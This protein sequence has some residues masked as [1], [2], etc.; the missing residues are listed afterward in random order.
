MR[1]FEFDEDREKERYVEIMPV[2]FRVQHLILMIT[3]GV[4]F[5]SGFTVLFHRTR[6]SE[7]LVAME[8]GVEVRGLLH[9]SA[10]V[11]LLFLVLYHLYYILFSRE[12]REEFQKLKLQ[13][14]DIADFIGV[15]RFSLRLSDVYP[16]LDRYSYK[17]KFQYWG[18]NTGLLIMILSGFILW[19]ETASMLLFPKWVLD[20]VLIIHGYEGMIVF[21]ILLFWHLYNVHCSPGNFPM[22]RVWITGKVDRELYS[23]DRRGYTGKK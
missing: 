13:K 7:L 8:G 10:A 19:F 14:K 17:E 1:V 20:I 4:L 22:N 23:R 18:V 5:L 11:V 12:G 3:V 21:I 2:F 16:D 9:R 15:L 6:A